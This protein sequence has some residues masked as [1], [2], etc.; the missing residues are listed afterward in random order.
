MTEYWSVFQ[1]LF[2]PNYIHSGPKLKNMCVLLF[3]LL[4]FF[5]MM[6]SDVRTLPQENR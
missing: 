4:F 6:I 1:R 5:Q 2:C 3:A